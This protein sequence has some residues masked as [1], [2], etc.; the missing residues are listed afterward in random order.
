MKH[1]MRICQRSAVAVLCDIGFLF[2]VPGQSHAASGPAV[3][4]ISDAAPGPGGCTD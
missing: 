2:L 3:S 4:L 1:E